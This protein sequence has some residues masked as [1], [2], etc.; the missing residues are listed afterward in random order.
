MNSKKQQQK[1]NQSSNKIRNS[2][3]Q[4]YTQIPFMTEHWNSVDYGSL[5]FI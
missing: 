4:N 1:H 2:A 5:I 3:R